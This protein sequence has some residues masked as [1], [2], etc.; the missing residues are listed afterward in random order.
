MRSA[1]VVHDPQVDLNVRQGLAVELVDVGPTEAILAGDGKGDGVRHRGLSGVV[2]PGDKAH[3]AEVKGLLLLKTFEAGNGHSDDLKPADFFHNSPSLCGDLIAFQQIDHLIVSAPLLVQTDIAK[4]DA[5]GQLGVVSVPQADE[6]S[7]LPVT[8]ADGGQ[9]PVRGQLPI[10]D[11]VIKGEGSG[12]GRAGG[13]WRCRLS[14]CGCSRRS[15][16]LGSR[17]LS[18]KHLGIPGVQRFAA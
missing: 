5:L 6:L 7:A 8:K 4:A 11:G 18:L 15:W 10:L 12:F 13:G 3:Q 14:G 17:G 2:G 16:L 9:L 1:L